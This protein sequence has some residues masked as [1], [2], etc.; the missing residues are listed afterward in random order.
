MIRENMPSGAK[1]HCIHR[2]EAICPKYMV[3]SGP[4]EIRS[5]MPLLLIGGMNGELPLSMSFLISRIMQSGL[6]AMI[7]RQIEPEQDGTLNWMQMTASI[8]LKRIPRVILMASKWRLSSQRPMANMYICTS[9]A[10]CSLLLE[11]KP[12]RERFTILQAQRIMAQ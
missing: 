1:T 10:I 12:R 9:P 6:T 4:Q 5:M 8:I 2:V 11:C 7:Q 3:V